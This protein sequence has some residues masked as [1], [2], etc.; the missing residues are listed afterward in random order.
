MKSKNNRIIE[1]FFYQSKVIIALILIGLASISASAQ[2]TNQNSPTP[3]ISNEIS[4]K[5][6]ARSIGDSRLTNYYFAFNANKGDVFINIVTENL[7]GDID[8]FTVDGLNPL[9]KIK[10]FSDVS[11]NETG[12]VV[13]LRKFEKLLLRIQGRS[14]NDDPATFRIKFAG[15][16]QPLENV[17]QTEEQAFPEINVRNQGENRVS[18]V[19][20]IIE[21]IRKP[22]PAPKVVAESVAEQKIENP[23]VEEKKIPAQNKEITVKSV[24][25]MAKMEDSTKIQIT[26][27]KVEET[28][29]T[30]AE[31]TEITKPEV[32]ITENPQK[33]ETP[34]NSEVLTENKP[35]ELE[36]E[37]EKV[38]E[39]ITE[40]PKVEEP[41]KNIEK[42]IESTPR[43]VQPL[44]PEQLKNIFLVV[45][46][47]DGK[48]IKESLNKVFSFNVNQG[49]LTIITYDGK[50]SRYSMLDVEKLSMEEAEN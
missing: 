27:E 31:T 33:V 26:R 5:I 29:E 9:T 34:E 20:T 24:D 15:S 30:V 10:I 11:D 6:N 13:Y 18:S 40:T 4:G 7:D 38:A 2:S 25:E 44:K 50:V 35:V 28:T 22:T 19:G 8:I 12:R 23:V 46:F 1:V 17:G 43:V 16:F 49:I 36:V 48:V 21:P 37:K 45:N 42:E 3:I 41:G 14:P 47:K 32:V 39:Q